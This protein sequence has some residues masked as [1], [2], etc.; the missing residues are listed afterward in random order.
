MKIALIGYGKMG[1]AIE[2][3]ALDQ[4]HEIAGRIDLENKKDINI[5]LKNA[6]VAIEFSRPESAYDNILTC[7]E[8]AVPVVSGTTGWLDRYQEISEK[9]KAHNGSF[10]FASNFSVGVN[11]FFNLNEY[12]AQIIAAYPE[13]QLNITES[14]HRHKKDAP[15]GTALSLAEGIIGKGPYSSWHL[16]P[17]EGSQNSIPITAIREGEIFGRHTI[18]Y[19]SVNDSITIEHDA[20]NRDGFAYGA[21][22][23]AQYIR[24]KKGVFTMKEVLALDQIG[25]LHQDR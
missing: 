3:L 18:Q 4:G 21:L 24:D 10:L 22:L 7:I 23:A 19:T 15:S 8:S 5:M 11:L 16:T 25:K 20:H 2:R 12:L 13:Y 9:V 1:Q 14:H 6:D 17:N